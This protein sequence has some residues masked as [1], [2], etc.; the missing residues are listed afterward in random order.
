MQ[1][2]GGEEDE[3]PGVNDGVDRD[4]AEGDQVLEVG[5]SRKSYGV[6]VHPDLRDRES[7][8]EEGSEK[9]EITLTAKV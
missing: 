1:H 5:L 2:A 6:H 4:E 8:E 7:K 9:R 3:N